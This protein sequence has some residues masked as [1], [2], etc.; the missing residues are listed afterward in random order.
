LSQPKK[1]FSAAGVAGVRAANGERCWDAGLAAV[2][3]F[4]TTIGAGMSGSTP[5]MTG[6]CLLCFSWLRRVTK[7]GSS[8]SSAIL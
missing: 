3:G 4:G 1:P 6:S 2:S 8:I 5:L 7:V